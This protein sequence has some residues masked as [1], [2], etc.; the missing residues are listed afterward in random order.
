MQ[1]QLIILYVGIIS[2]EKLAILNYEN[3]NIIDGYHLVFVAG[4]ID[5]IKCIYPT[6]IA[7]EELMKI[8]K[9]NMKL[10]NKLL[11]DK[12]QPQNNFLKQIL[13]KL[14]LERVIKWKK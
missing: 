6:F 1:R 13:R 10:L 8:Q 11:K 9:E 3:S 4:Y 5:E 14:K 2:P 7:D 12:L